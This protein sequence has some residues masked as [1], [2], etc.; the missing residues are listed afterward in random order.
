[1]LILLI[2]GLK[3]TGAFEA[4][5]QALPPRIAAATAVHPLT[6]T[7]HDLRDPALTASSALEATLRALTSRTARQTS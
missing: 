5:T 1:M 3:A 7:A 6:R 4:V 2:L